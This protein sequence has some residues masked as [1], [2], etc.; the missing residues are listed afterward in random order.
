MNANELAR[1]I[2]HWTDAMLL[3][4]LVQ[5]PHLNV[6]DSWDLRDWEASDVPNGI[7]FQRRDAQGNVLE[8]VEAIN[9]PE[10]D[11]LEFEHTLA[12]WSVPTQLVMAGGTKRGAGSEKSPSWA[13]AV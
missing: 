7:R 5:S 2:D 4:E 8:A 13:G 6:G 3:A 12:G 9:A 1:L 11:R 10:S